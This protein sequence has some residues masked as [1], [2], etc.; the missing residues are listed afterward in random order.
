MK[1]N[2]LSAV[3]TAYINDNNFYLYSNFQKQS[4]KVIY[5][6]TEFQESKKSILT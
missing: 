5:N 1:L 3:T 4:D 6:I 2:I